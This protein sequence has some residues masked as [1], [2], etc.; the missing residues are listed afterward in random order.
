MVADGSVNPSFAECRSQP[1]PL[2]QYQRGLPH[3]NP[4]FHV[5]MS[6]GMRIQNERFTGG[7]DML[8]NG[9]ALEVKIADAEALQVETPAEAV[10]ILTRNGMPVSGAI[11]EVE[12][13]MTHAGM[14][15]I[16]VSATE[17]A[18]GEYR[19]PLEWTMGGDWLL[20]IRGTLP[21]GTEIEQ[22]VDGLTVE[23]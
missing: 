17:V 1:E 5:E 11:L 6:V 21:D 13:N 23:S 10:I 20:T 16:F 9:V 15:P 2:H 7:A 18:P 14:E 12:G 8:P 22:Q 4:L 19:A 3:G